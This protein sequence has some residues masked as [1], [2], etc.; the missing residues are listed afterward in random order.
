L[1][2]PPPSERGLTALVLLRKA[3]VQQGQRVLVY[4]DSGSGG[5]YA[6][7]LAVAFG[8]RVTGVCSAANLDLVKS[9][10]AEK[11]IDYTDQDFTQIDKT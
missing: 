6:V 8:A 11:V 3:K 10:G 1:S 4:G 7:Q 9:L 5:A 2:K